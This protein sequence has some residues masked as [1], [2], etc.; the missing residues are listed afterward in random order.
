MAEPFARVSE[1]LRG[2]EGVKMF[3]YSMA[4]V[5]AIAVSVV[6]LAVL[7]GPLGVRAWVASTI[8]TAV[9]CIPS[10]YLNRCWAWGRDGRSHFL[11]EILPF[12]S[13]AFLGWGI[14]TLCVHAM[15]DYAKSNGFSHLFRTG[16]V[17]LVY[18]A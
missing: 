16:S 8:A 17:T 18:V 4:S 5:V 15:E 10:Y 13:L 9:A 7:N 1:Y 2:P 6:C 12:W 14:S 3:R 11:K